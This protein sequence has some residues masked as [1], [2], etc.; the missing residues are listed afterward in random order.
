MDRVTWLKEM[1]CD[2]EEQYDTRWA[3]LYG[4]KWGQQ[5]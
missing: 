3:S 2:C 5:N 1:R 4:E